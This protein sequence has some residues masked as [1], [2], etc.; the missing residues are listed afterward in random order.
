M[1]AVGL[2]LL[3][4]L[5]FATSTVVQHRAVTSAHAAPGRR[6]ALRL[7]LG[8]LTDR[9]WL[10]GQLAAVA[11]VALHALALRSGPVVLVQPVL[12]A[13]LV[14]SLAL[15][16]LVDRHHPDRRKPVR[17]EWLAAGVVVVGLTV[18][19]LTA[20]P[21]AGSA[22]GRPLVLAGAAAGEL[23]LAAAAFAWSRRPNAPHRALV[24]GVAAGAGF[25]VTGL[26]LKDVVAH[27][28]SSWEDSWSLLALVIV[29]A[30]AFP[31][32][33]LAYRAGHLIE[34]LPTM[35]VLEPVVAVALAS[36]AFG[37]TLA[38]GWARAGQLGGMVLLTA[39]V[40]SLARHQV[41]PAP[42]H[43]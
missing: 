37:E 21:A 42:A 11:G 3:S 2:A 40:V 29:G 20:R 22:S 12:S 17:A 41:G 4:A 38:G 34:S 10:A 31:A 26:L 9:A 24:L 6:R 27:P 19:L 28:F 43:I 16:A 18:F 23:L 13:G 5:S 15:G 39:G 32:A 1:I 33:Q 36:L 25:G 14:F 8:L 7:V 30:L 35:T